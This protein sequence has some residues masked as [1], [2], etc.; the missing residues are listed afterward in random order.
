M[1]AR[2]NRNGRG[3]PM[4]NWYHEILGRK[5]PH[6]LP[7]K[8]E[9]DSSLEESIYGPFGLRGMTLSFKYT[10]RDV[11]RVHQTMILLPWFF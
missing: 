9:S 3:H 4:I 7:N 10:R 5:L 8:Q 2:P 6:P 11:E 1:K